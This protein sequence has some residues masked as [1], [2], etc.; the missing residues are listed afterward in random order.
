MV[1]QLAQIA[2]YLALHSSLFGPNGSVNCDYIITN[3]I[4]FFFNWLKMY[5]PKAYTITIIEPIW[6]ML[7]NVSKTSD[8]SQYYIQKGCQGVAK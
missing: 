1:Q 8:A 3:D 2:F 6:P 7:Q 4:N 5:S